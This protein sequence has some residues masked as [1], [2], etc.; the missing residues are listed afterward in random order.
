VGELLED[1]VDADAVAQ[2]TSEILDRVFDYPRVVADV[3]SPYSAR[4]GL[5][6]NDGLRLLDEFLL[7]AGNPD[8]ERILAEATSR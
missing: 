4:F 3:L 1:R 5:P 8:R 6:P 7:R 2:I